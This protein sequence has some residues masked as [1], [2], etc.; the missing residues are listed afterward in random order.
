MS[1]RFSFEFSVLSFLPLWVSILI[2]CI[3]S[4]VI[5]NQPTGTEMTLLVVVPTM[6]VI[7]SLEII[8]IFRDRNPPAEDFEEGLVV[9]KCVKQKAVTTEYIL[10][11]VLPLYTFDFTNWCSVLQFATVIGT[12]VLLYAKY[13]ELPPNV[14]LEL[15]G[16]SRFTCRFSDGR[17]RFVLAKKIEEGPSKLNFRTFGNDVFLLLSNEDK[18]RNQ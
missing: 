6:L 2:A 13:Y 4:V 7:S 11:C 1:H 18:E 16:Y 5:R 9:V 3:Q 15:M 17:E 10:A 14:V 12:I 8:G